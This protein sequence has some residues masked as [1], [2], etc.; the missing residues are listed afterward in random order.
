MPLTLATSYPAFWFLPLLLLAWVAALPVGIGALV[1]GKRKIA[2]V[3][4]AVYV[5][6]GIWL[7][8]AAIIEPAEDAKATAIFAT[9]FLLVGALLA[10][11]RRRPIAIEYRIAQLADVP[12]LET[13]IPI[14]ARKLL[15]DFCTP[16][17]IEG[18]LGTVFGVDTQLIRD[19]TYF[20]AV[21]QDRI[22]GCGGWSRRK[23]SYGG[24]KGKKGEDPLRDPRT[25][26][27]MIRAFF[28]DPD[29]ARRGIGREFI[30]LSEEAADGAGFRGIDIVATPAGEPL[31]AACGYVVMER[32]EIPLANGAAMPAVRMGKRPHHSAV[33]P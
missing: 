28:V 20:V 25:E 22:V 13:L 6:T 32:F 7:M 21:A 14:S 30:R 3:C 19:G 8:G 18:A 12:A 2:V 4:G 26:P 27:A 24:D 29:F 16:E 31:Y 5:V 17:Q 15:A 10:T 23:T 1:A 9:L 11:V 33:S